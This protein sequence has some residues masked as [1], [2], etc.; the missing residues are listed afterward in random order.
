[1]KKYSFAISLTLLAISCQVL[2]LF[3]YQPVIGKAPN[4]FVQLFPA[5]FLI[6]NLLMHNILVN[7]AKNQPKKFVS[8]FMG[9][10]TGKMMISLIFVLIVGLASR[11]DFKA[12]AITF[13]VFYLLFMVL[14]VLFIVRDLK[15]L[16]NN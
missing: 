11:P 8:R 5:Y 7:T 16:K 15:Q 2:I 9:L 10:T 4:L 12:P 1:M 3:V 6:I 13:V 14:E